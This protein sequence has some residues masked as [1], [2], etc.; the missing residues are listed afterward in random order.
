[1][2]SSINIAQLQLP[3][4]LALAVAVCLA[5]LERFFS[6]YLCEYKRK[7]VV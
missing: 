4:H 3:A 6:L 7:K 1:M 5:L 2:A